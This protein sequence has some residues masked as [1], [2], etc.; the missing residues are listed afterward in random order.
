MRIVYERPP[1]FALVDRQFHVAGKPVI[2][3]WGDRIYNPERINIPKQIIEHEEVHGARQTTDDKAIW[4]WWD[5]YLID[6]SFRFEEELIAH[7]VEY[8]AYCKRHRGGGA[9][10]KY[11]DFTARRLSSP[12]YGNVVTHNEAIARIIAP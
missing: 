1:N 7:R 12:L 6:P 2:F 10:K 5:R 8:R 9:Q 11:L 4:A 3:S